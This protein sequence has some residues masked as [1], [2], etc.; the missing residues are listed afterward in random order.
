MSARQKTLVILQARLGSQRLPGK[1]LSPVGRWPL[2]EYCLTRLLASGVG[3][4]VLATTTRPEDG[5]LVSLGRHM[6]V[7]VSRGPVEDVLARYARVAEAYPDAEVI[8]RATGDNPFV[9]I[10]AAARA[11][12]AL[13][14]GAAYAVEEGLPLG[15]AVEAMSRAALLRADREATS[16]YDREHVTPWIKRES[17]LVR[18]AL[19]APERVRAPEVRLTVD[20]LNDLLCARHIAATVAARGQDP[21][22]APLSDI[23]VAARR[24]PAEDVA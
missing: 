19:R 6:G 23:I 14:S 17:S 22:M 11:V 18:V 8:V 4:V 20:T 5:A 21:R 10:D 12:D 7:P 3:D 16:P 2:L 13:G 15:A 9:D 24:G 1:V